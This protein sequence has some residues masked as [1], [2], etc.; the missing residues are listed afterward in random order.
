[1]PLIKGNEEHEL[2]ISKLPKASIGKSCIRF[3]KIS[4]IDL[5]IL[6]EVVQTSNKFPAMGAV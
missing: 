1:L 6:K 5:D 3:K 2:I 4:D